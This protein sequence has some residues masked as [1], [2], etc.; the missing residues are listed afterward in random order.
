MDDG[1]RLF[2]DL[3]L[4]FFAV[5]AK[6]HLQGVFS[7]VAFGGAVCLMIGI[8]LGLA[9]PRRALLLFLLPVAF[10]QL[11]VLTAW[12][13]HSAF[14]EGGPVLSLVFACLQA[15]VIGTAVLMNRAAWLP[16]LCLSAFCGI[17]AYYAHVAAATVLN[18][19][20]VS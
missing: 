8:V 10:S 17:Y 13:L 11:L 16:S 15:A 2:L 6:P 9:R 7:A 3:H 5:L 18:S 14:P 20:P 19:L 12:P 1:I 4:W